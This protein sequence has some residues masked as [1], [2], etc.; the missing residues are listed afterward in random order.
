MALPR[1]LGLLLLLSSTLFGVCQAIVLKTSGRFIVDPSGKRVKF[2]CVNWAGHMET[3]IPEGLQHQPVDTISSWIANNGFNCVRLTYSID[4]ALNLGQSVSA[5][6]TAAASA[7]GVSSSQMSSL[8]SSVQS[9]NSFVSSS[10]VQGVFD[11]VIKSLESHN[12][13]VILDNHVSRASW[14]CGT[15]DG[16]GWFKQGSGYNAA[17]SQYFDVPNW[18]KGLQSMATLA[19]SHPNVVAMSLRNELRTV[20]GQ[21][22]NNNDWYTYIGQGASAIHNTNSNLLIVIGGTSYALNLGMLY[23]KPLDRS[24]FPDKVVWEVHSYSW[25]YGSG[26]ATNCQSLA[27][28][29]GNG[30]GYLLAEGKPYTGPLWMSEFGVP[31]TLKSGDSDYQYLQ[32]LRQYLESNDADW[33]YWALQGDYYVRDKSINLSESFGL[34]KDDWSGTRNPSF[35]GYLGKMRDVTQGP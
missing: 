21:N 24:A 22:S 35:L 32:C 9:K 29:I 28:T 11:T 6:F 13:L 16:N 18:L 26:V 30:A 1:L 23:D 14:C 15:S 20:S 27:T 19:K 31:Q 34:L 12:I 33:S 2:R 7:A 25:S 8:Y 17:N 3:H 5:A 10:T 4:A